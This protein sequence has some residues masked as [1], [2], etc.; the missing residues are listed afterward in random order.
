MNNRL[1]QIRLD[2]NMSQ[3]EFGKK[4]GIESRSHISS[5]EKGNR[6]IT[7]RIIND[8]CREFNVREEWLRDGELPIYNEKDGSFTELLSDLDDSDDDFIKSI[9]KIYMGLDKDSKDA[10]KKIALNMAEEY[11]K[12]S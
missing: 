6:N 3:E 12:R 10:L 4:I 7:D 1:K 5:L 2:N 11:K 9:I 8:V